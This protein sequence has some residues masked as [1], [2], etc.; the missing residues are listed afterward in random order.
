[1]D[2]A[3]SVS[4]LIRRCFAAFETR[5]RHTLESLLSDDFIFSSPQD[6][7]IGKATYF[8]RCW[9]Y[10]ENVEFFRIEKLFDQGNEAFVR[11]V[12]KPKDRPAFRNTEF[13]RVE[14]GQVVEVQVYF[15]APTGD[16]PPG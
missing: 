3:S 11:Y 6:D 13:F 9:P 4:N 12:C 1:V 5:D 15:G 14:H 16:I 2:P 8:E 10:G 7:R